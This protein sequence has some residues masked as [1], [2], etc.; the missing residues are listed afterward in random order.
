MF[1]EKIYDTFV[2]F[3]GVGNNDWDKTKLILVS[4]LSIL[5]DFLIESGVY[6]LARFVVISSSSAVNIGVSVYNLLESRIQI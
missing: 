1:E 5:V 3:T 4:C 6:R 2:H